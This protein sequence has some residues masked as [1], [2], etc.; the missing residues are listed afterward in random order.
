MHEYVTCFWRRPPPPSPH[1]PHEFT[2][3]ICHM[4]FSHFDTFSIYLYICSCLFI[5]PSRLRYLSTAPPRLWMI[6]R[7]KDA[8]CRCKL[9]I[10]TYLPW[11]NIVINYSILPT[12]TR[13][14]TIYRINDSTR[15]TF[16]RQFCFITSRERKNLNICVV[17]FFRRIDY[18]WEI[19]FYSRMGTSFLIHQMF[20]KKT[21]KSEKTRQFLTDAYNSNHRAVAAGGGQTFLAK[22]YKNF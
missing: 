16:T 8:H 2:A 9:L 7:A 1:S 6:H 11:Y 15:C 18:G 4:I 14:H 20:W 19:L 21:F 22:L 17:F 5:R 12:W 10:R 13:G 3:R